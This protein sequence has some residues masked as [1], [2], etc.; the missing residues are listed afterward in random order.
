MWTYSAIIKRN[1][2]FLSTIFVG[3]FAT[4]MYVKIY[5]DGRGGV[6]D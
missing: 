2:V 5:G 3:A 6:E 4:E 1:F